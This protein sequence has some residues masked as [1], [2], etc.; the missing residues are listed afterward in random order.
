MYIHEMEI[1]CMFLTVVILS[2]HFVLSYYL[3]WLSEFLLSLTSFL[4]YCMLIRVCWMEWGVSCW[5]CLVSKCVCASPCPSSPSGPSARWDW[6]SYTWLMSNDICCKFYL[7]PLSRHLIS[8]CSVT[9][10]PKWHIIAN[11]N[12]QYSKTLNRPHTKIDMM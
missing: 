9:L 6:T 2:L 4:L 5:C 10:S 8:V 1:L 3:T 7:S 12:K 11:N